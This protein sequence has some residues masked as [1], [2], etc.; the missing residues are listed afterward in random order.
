MPKYKYVLGY[1]LTSPPKWLLAI[2]RE[3]IKN[4]W[5]R[6]NACVVHRENSKTPFLH[7]RACE[8]HGERVGDRGQE[9]KTEQS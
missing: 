8:V 2:A 5:C 6:D 7:K 9:D 3:K 4:D 1:T